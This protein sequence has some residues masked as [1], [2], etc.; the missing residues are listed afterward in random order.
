MTSLWSK[1]RLNTQIAIASST[2]LAVT[3]LI[4]TA[5][6]VHTQQ[7]TMRDALLQNSMALGRNLSSTITYHSIQSEYDAI[8]ESLLKSAEFPEVKSIK[9]YDL[10]GAIQNNIIRKKSGE[11]II[12]YANKST[13]LPL[14]LKNRV[15]SLTIINKNT[16]FIWYPLKTT[17]VIGWLNLEIS[18]AE[19]NKRRADIIK[20]NVIGSVIAIVLNI[21]ILLVILITPTKKIQSAIKVTQ[22]LDSLKPKL[23]KES[24]G[25]HDLNKLFSALNSVALRLNAQ[26]TEIQN[27]TY[28]LTQN[29]IELS[30]AKD[31][32]ELSKE[33]FDRAINGA[34]DGLWD[35]SLETSKVW[36]S[37]RFNSLLSQ[38]R[39]DISTNIQI[40]EFINYFHPDDSKAIKLIFNSK[41][42]AN[43]TLD[44]QCRLRTD[45]KEYTWFRIR[46]RKY[47]NSE[48]IPVHI[49]GSLMDISEQIRV[50]KMKD[51]FVSTIS[52][53]LR[54]PLTSIKGS[55]E[56]INSGVMG[57]VN[58]KMIPLL[59]I[60]CRN[61][62][63]LSQLINDILDISK[64]ESG[65]VDSHLEKIELV[66]FLKETIELNQGM[67]I[68][69]NVA[70]SLNAEV[71][72]AWINLDKRSL[73]KI[74]NNLI[75]NAIK[76]SDNEKEVS[77]RLLKHKTH[78][79]IAI[80]D[81]GLGISK[82]YQPF[83]FTKFTQEQSSLTRSVGG[84]GLG[85][86]IAKS[87]IE[88]LKGDLSY[89][90]SATEGTT[91]FV[92]L[93]AINNK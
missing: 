69:F 79:R 32:L 46:G 41:I 29:N 75:S 26:H 16:L 77:V 11:I 4:T 93:P 70:L 54:T 23:T 20:R 3:I 92:D 22:Q 40:N 43:E 27:Q 10:N 7:T 47:N 52:H 31:E 62:E 89:T 13:L 64:I 44:I 67:A 86:S 48:G 83:L 61:S 57:E 49:A 85:L 17:N 81:T 33:R 63:H 84:S 2:L 39:I 78:Y 71:S 37:Q 36:C 91:F 58:K 6:N 30:Y 82:E 51:E 35:Y 73:H 19:L 55:L 88:Q 45:D 74:M 5:F 21:L 66:N 56:L 1:L 25:S 53:E 15:E 50:D 76:F 24:G 59:D 8:E 9:L 38:N 90:T 34:N 72:N 28:E 14:Q 60:A 87:L 12:S 68:K 42:I 18:L 80:K 65:N